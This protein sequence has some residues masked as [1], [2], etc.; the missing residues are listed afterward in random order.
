MYTLYWN[1][2]TRAASVHMLLEEAGIPYQ[3]HHID[4][5]R[6]EHQSPDY[7]ALNPKGLVPTLVTDTGDVLSETG[8]MLMHIADRQ[9][10]KGLVPSPDDPARGAF[11]DWFFYHLCVLQ[12]P[13]K[14]YHFPHRYSSDATHIDGITERATQTI[15]SHWNYLEA[16][17]ATNG[18]FHLG[19]RFGLNDIL[20]ATYCVF[21]SGIPDFCTRF[22]AVARCYELVKS[23]PALTAILQDH[24]TPTP[25]T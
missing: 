25:R 18:P 4:I 21:T 14:R 1:R 17:L 2:R 22:P 11:L 7:L 8:A 10:V 9:D 19:A 23:R 20:L 5:S 15:E 16:H 6:G 24:E 13:Y 12:E 3:L